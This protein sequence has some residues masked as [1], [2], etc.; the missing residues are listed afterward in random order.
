VSDTYL[1]WWLPADHPRRQPPAPD[2]PGEIPIPPP[3]LPPPSEVS[4]PALRMLVSLASAT[5]SGAFAEV[6]VYKGGSAY[7]LA[8]VARE[9]S[10]ELH[11]F[12]TFTGL[13]PKGPQDF[14]FGD[15]TFGDTSEAAV[16][17]V[18]PGAIIHAGLFPATL[19]EDMPPA[20]FVHVD[21]DR[22]QSVKDCIVAFRP[23]LVP[24]GVMLFDDYDGITGAI[25]AV[26]E[27]FPGGVER[28][29]EGKGYWRKPVEEKDGGT[30]QGGANEVGGGGEGTDTRSTRSASGS[31]PDEHTRP[32]GGG[33][34][35]RDE[36]G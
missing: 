23:L 27:A 26:D 2:V 18:V 8:R 32:S 13:P 35:I 25:Q 14:H 28:T 31:L 11:L 19:P 17:A 20:A 15:G 3:T 21:C 33:E 5:P 24:G 7:H 6:G 22:Y 30:T 1:P 4:A 29:P 36:S 9:Q 16:R 34:G 12:D 10:R